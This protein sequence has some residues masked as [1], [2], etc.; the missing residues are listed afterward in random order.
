MALKICLLTDN[1]Y[2]FIKFREIIL[3][4]GLKDVSFEYFC[5]PGSDDMFSEFDDVSVIDVKKDYKAFINNADLVI[6]CHCKKIFPA[7]LTNNVRCVNV[8]PGLNPYNRGWYPQVFAINNGLPHGATIH[9][10]DEKIDHG[11]IIV[12]RTVDINL[13]DTSLDVYE[14]VVEAEVKL[15]EEN[16]E[17]II[18]GRY[19][20][21]PML[22]EGN[23]NSIR[24]FKDM[25]QIDL[26][27]TGTFREF[28]NL[29]RSLTHEPYSNAYIVDEDGKKIRIKVKLDVEG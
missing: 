23:Y 25:L 22:I 24:D 5:S 13:E 18:Y 26:D 19:Q 3:N 17:S 6:S 21:H 12:Q 1:K 29:L 27:Y 16:F 28:Y 7:E 11:D 4:N 14:R 9:E 20:A 10:M 2:I 15:F 8:H